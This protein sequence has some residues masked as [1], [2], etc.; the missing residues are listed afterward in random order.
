FEVRDSAREALV[1]DR[2]SAQAGQARLDPRSVRRLF[3]KL[4]E[5]SRRV[6]SRAAAP[7]S[8]PD[9][10]TVIR[11]ALSRLDDRIVASLAAAA[12]I[13]EGAL[14]ADR[15]TLLDRPLEE[16]EIEELRAA[17]LS[18]GAKGGKP[19]AAPRGLPLGSGIELVGSGP[20]L[21]NLGAGASDLSH[22]GGTEARAGTAAGGQVELRFGRKIL[23]V[24]PLAG[25]LAN[26]DGGVMGYA[27][28]AFELAWRRL[29]VSPVL[30]LGA[31]EE[32]DSKLLGGVFL[33]HVGGNGMVELD[34]GIRIGV[35]FAHI[36]NAFIHEENPGTEF[37]ML[38]AMMPLPF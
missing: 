5:L 29:R 38:G 10:E 24:S 7:E 8:A 23:F 21:L 9:L 30:S 2:A 22:I 12:P 1:L 19:I 14:G 15:L 3:E 34:N 18:A 20:S 27:G 37:V 25:V 26:S 6:Q 16:S 13:A 35:T 17:L 36:S 32:G 33:F 4:I 28:G 11:P 31:Y